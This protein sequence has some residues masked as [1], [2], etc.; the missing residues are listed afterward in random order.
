MNRTKTMISDN[1]TRKLSNERVTIAPSLLASDFA[2]L[3]SELRKLE[4]AG[5]RVVHI[6]VMDGCF[7]PNIS[8]G[9]PVVESIRRVTTLKLDVHLMIVEPERYIEAFR[10]AGADSL[11]VH[12]EAV[13]EPTSILNRIRELGAAPGL[14]L[15]Y[16]T[17]VETMLPY[18]KE[19]DILLV[20]SVPAGFGG[21][22]FRYD[23][24][25][26]VRALRTAARPDALIEID[27]GIDADTIG[28][29]AE[30]GANLFA[31]GTSVFGSADYGAQ[32]TL[33]ER[34]AHDALLEKELA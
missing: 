11:S 8:V 16:G 32:I 3:E 9:V 6:D 10:D 19:A 24:L 21:Q 4:E 12:I 29:A 20:M 26:S 33:L 5:V 23:A 14:V 17:P 31:V 1:W 34:A 7:V 28:A 27:G 15:N 2:N 22:T 25:D 18:A 13:P 30:A